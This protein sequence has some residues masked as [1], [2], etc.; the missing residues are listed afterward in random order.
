MKLRKKKLFDFPQVYTASAFR[1]DGKLC[2]GAGPEVAG[3]A[4]LM[5]VSSR[6]SSVIAEGVGGMMCLIPFPQR[7]GRLISVMGLFPPFKGLE[8]GIYVHSRRKEGV[9]QT[10]KMIH[11]PFAH[12]CETLTAGGRSLLFSAT[13]SRHK[14]E[15]SDWS[16]PG[17]VCLT[18]IKEEEDDP[19]DY[20]VVIDK[21]YRN[22]GMLKTSFGQ[23]EAVCVSGEQGIFALYPEGGGIVTRQ[24]F[25]REVSEFALVDMDGDG[26]KELVTIEPFHGHSL[27][28]YTQSAGRWEKVYDS[29]LSFGHGLSAG[30]LGGRPSV[31]VGNRSGDASLILLQ[32]DGRRISSRLIES[33]TGTTQT[34]FFSHEG[35]DYL[36]CA[37][38]LKGEV[39]LYT[40]LTNNQ[41]I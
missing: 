18:V 28:V 11:L 35:T 25:D 9:W 5:D 17:Q 3:E 29:P 24:L 27:N 33:H 36:L 2:V 37:N 38:Q 26:N 13:V 4:V 20:E 21:L 41:R 40:P 32:T 23:Q 1:L 6:R 39:A 12:R 16:L 7:S 30:R 22:H 31:A 34:Q 8:A 14:S 19:W 15:P 10:A